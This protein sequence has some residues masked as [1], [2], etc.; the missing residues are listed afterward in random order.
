VWKPSKQNEGIGHTI[1]QWIVV[2]ASASI[3][4]SLRQIRA[5]AA[6]RSFLMNTLVDGGVSRPAENR[7]VGSRQAARHA[8][9]AH[10]LMRDAL[11]R[12]LEAEIRGLLMAARV[13]GFRIAIEAG[14]PVV[15]EQ[16]A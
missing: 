2:P 5:E 6:A 7:D 9:H 8:A 11:K 3:G 15:T 12:E 1:V 16:P 10:S 13:H 14:K 4:P